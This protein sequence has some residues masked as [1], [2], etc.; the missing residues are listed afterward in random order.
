MYVTEQARPEPTAIP[1]V[2]HTT[3]AGAAEG[4][5]Q[6]SLWRQTLAPGAATPPHSHDCDEVVLC[7]GGWG[8][9]HID[10][11]AHRFGPE[12]TIVLPRGTLHQIF[13]VGEVPMEILGVFGATPVGT[14]LPDGAALPLP[15]RS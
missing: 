1:G 10:G 3:Y 11:Q 5:K 9:V 14:F 15:W 12:S 13:N 6:L 8:E 2:A 7:Q 4:L